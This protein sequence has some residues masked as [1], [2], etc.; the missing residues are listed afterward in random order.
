MEVDG[1]LFIHQNSYIDKVCNLYSKFKFPISSLPIPKGQVL[2]K[3][4]SPCTKQEVEEM[5]NLPHRNLLGS[6][7]FIAGRTRPDIVYA[8]NL[9]SQFQSNPGIKHWQS[10]LKL[11]GYLQSTRNYKLDLSKVNNLN[12]KCYSDSDFAADRDDRVSI[13]K[14]AKENIV[15]KVVDLKRKLED[16]KLEVQD[17]L[18]R[19]YVDFIPQYLK[20]DKLIED[21]DDVTSEYE[22]LRSQ[23]EKEIR[24][25][26]VS[27]VVEFEDVI[28]DLKKVKELKTAVSDMISL[29]QLLEDAKKT[30]SK[31]GYLNSVR[32]LLEL[33]KVVGKVDPNYKKNIAAISTLISEF[34]VAREDAI[35]QLETLWR[36]E[37]TII[38]S[39]KNGKKTLSIKFNKTTTEGECKEILLALRLLKQLKPMLKEFGKKFLNEVCEMLLSRTVKLELSDKA[40]ELYIYIV[41]EH[42]PEPSQIFD[43]L[44]TIF[45][46]LHDEFFHFPVTSP[47]EE[48]SQSAMNEFGSVISEEFSELIIEKC[49][50]MAIPKQSKQL[51]TFH[52][53]IHAAE[54]FCRFLQELEFISCSGSN[55]QNFI[56]SVD[57]LPANKMAQDLLSRARSLMKKSLHKTVSV[58]YESPTNAA[59]LK[60]G[61]NEMVNTQNGLSAA[62]FLFP[63]CQISESVKDLISL[64]LVVKEEAKNIGP[65]HAFKLY[66]VARN[67]CELYC[68]VV[69]TYHKK[70]IESIP[71]QTAIFHNNCMFLAHQL[72]TLGSLYQSDFQTEISMTFVDLVPEVKKLGTEAFLAQMR[73]QK[74]QLLQLLQEQ[75]AFGSNILDDGAVSTAEKSIRQCLYQLQLL[76]NVWA[77]ILPVEVYF[78]SIG[79]L[80]NTCLEEIILRISSMEDIA[81]EAAGQLDSSFVILINQSPD[82]FKVP[83]IDKTDSIHFYVRNWFKFQELQLIL[84]ASMR[85]IVDRWASGKG[86]LA[87]HF[88]AAEVKHL[89]RALFQNTERRAAALAKIK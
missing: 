12:L 75:Q 16:I 22:S 44:K 46:F 74:H 9:L 42:S 51:E 25:Q 38:S 83:A 85:E 20:L 67:I 55:L 58:G 37:I 53:E 2:S 26:M 56:Y 68:C 69:P 62:T 81:A 27:S 40:P 70:E 72:Y 4:D 84:S 88:K 52:K 54:E 30:L 77:E 11:L 34:I 71:Q 78:K 23:V 80:L 60:N 33:E 21:I 87:A 3:L 10:L 82:F 73:H 15:L 63:K 65:A 13:G 86:P 8:V 7:A 18:K 59:A 89:I 66:Y 35:Y 47:E 61:L 76:K 43:L 19:R 14:L 57:T 45:K 49:L 50:K 36:Q 5:S 64:L 24:P 6:L 31:G 29:H 41:N 17:N 28:E 39:S 1:K 79:T 48:F 32:C